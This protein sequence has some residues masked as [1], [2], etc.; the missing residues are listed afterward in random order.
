MAPGL[1]P[2]G[3]GILR[4][5]VAVLPWPSLEAAPLEVPLGKV[6]DARVIIE[7]WRQASNRLR[8]DSALGHG[9][10]APEVL[11]PPPPA[12]VAPAHPLAQPRLGHGVV[13]TYCAGRQIHDSSPQAAQSGGELERGGGPPLSVGPAGRAR[14]LRFLV[15]SAG[16][17]P[18][19]GAGRVR[20][21][22][23][24]CPA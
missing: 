2:T 18:A 6:I 9:P 1:V 4:S 10:S 22:G 20:A 24:S 19:N 17:F 21:S 5:L 7:R 16:A 15:A 14:R 12:L 3:L 8:L 13:R 11:L 23:I